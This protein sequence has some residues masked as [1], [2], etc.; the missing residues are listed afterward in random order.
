MIDVHV[1]DSLD[2][3]TLDEPFEATVT[4]LSAALRN[5][6]PVFIGMTPD[7]RRVGVFTDK[8][9]HIEELASDE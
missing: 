9:T 1:Q 6:I 8:I 7:R 2:T 5:G 4:N 3:V